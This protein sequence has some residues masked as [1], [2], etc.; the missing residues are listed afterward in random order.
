MS[1]IDSAVKHISYTY[2]SFWQQVQRFYFF[3]E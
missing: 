3:N 2:F 1:V